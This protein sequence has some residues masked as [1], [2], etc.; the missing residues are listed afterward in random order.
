MINQPIHESQKIVKETKDKV[1][2]SFEVHPTCE[3]ISMLLGFRDEVKV[4]APKGLREK[5]KEILGS[6]IEEYKTN[7]Q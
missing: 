1:I 7:K 2:F 3:F 5:M 4:L 6:M